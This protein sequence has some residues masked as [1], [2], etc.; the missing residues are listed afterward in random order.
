MHKNYLKSI[1]LAV[2]VFTSTGN[3]SA[4]FFKNLAQK[5]VQMGLNE[6]VNALMKNT[7]INYG[8]STVV[9]E[10]SLEKLYGSSI[11]HVNQNNNEFIKVYKDYNLQ[12]SAGQLFR[13]NDYSIDL[14]IL[15]DTSL[16]ISHL[17]KR[18]PYNSEYVNGIKYT[19][20]VIKDS[21]IYSNEID[22]T[23]SFKAIVKNNM[24]G[25][26]FIPF[27]KFE[28]GKI[29]DLSSTAKANKEPI[30]TYKYFVPSK[31]NFIFTSIYF[32]LTY[33]K[34]DEI[35]TNETI[36]EWGKT[37]ISQKNDESNNSSTKDQN[38]FASAQT[39]VYSIDKNGYNKTSIL[40]V[41]DGKIYTIDK[42]GYNKTS[43]AMIE[44]NKIYTIDKNGYNK[45]S[46]LMVEDRKIY[47]IDKNGYNKTSIAM[48]EGN[49]V[50]TTDKN[51]YNKTSILMVEDGKI[52][53]ID[54]NGYNKTS[55]AMID[56][57]YSQNELVY[58]I[59]RIGLL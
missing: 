6:G 35:L 2:I 36:V 24:N 19:L 21:I 23:D 39:K 42:N 53:T 28:N 12:A 14:F 37:R 7:S 4:Q 17:I 48:I 58:I 9:F 45:T 57:D 32:K 41:Q 51:G 33:A 18:K 3:L 10:S 15:N 1:F 52:Y 47:T 27:A 43:V 55:I 44:G 31:A 30:G 49:K 50:Y 5:A 16:V 13:G 38:S 34:I 25:I 46:I 26:G 54:K 8:G 29:Y 56:G 11:W 40:M 59:T 22:N 20:F